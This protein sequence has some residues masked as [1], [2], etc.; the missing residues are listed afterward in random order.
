MV[1]PYNPKQSQPQAEACLSGAR[2]SSR[3]AT[4][5]AKRKEVVMERGPVETHA[6]GHPRQGGG[7]E[8]VLQHHLLAGI[9]DLAT[10]HGLEAL[11]PH[12]GLQA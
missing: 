6:P 9:Q 2:S 8:P 1:N 10:T 7:R 12:E 11:A 3:T 5:A 4:A